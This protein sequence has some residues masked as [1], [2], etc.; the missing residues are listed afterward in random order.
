MVWI[1]DT[2][3]S[4]HRLL[5]INHSSCIAICAIF[6]LINH[7]L[8]CNPLI[9]FSRLIRFQGLTNSEQFVR[10]CHL[11]SKGTTKH[12][13]VSR[14]SKLYIKIDINS[15]YVVGKYFVFVKSD[16]Q[17]IF[18]LPKMTPRGEGICFGPANN[19]RPISLKLACCKEKGIK[20]QDFTQIL[21]KI[22][23]W[24]ARIILNTLYFLLSMIANA[25]VPCACPPPQY[26]RPFV[27]SCYYMGG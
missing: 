27:T 6:S 8:P 3:P 24:T 21:L 12:R 26:A 16:T 14:E 5:V 11:N 17:L 22:A 25:H 18:L 4:K 15:V 7:G 13:D 9:S 19:C 10:R 20:I 2:F 23:P 1:F